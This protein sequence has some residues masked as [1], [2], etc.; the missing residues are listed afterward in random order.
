MEEVLVF[1]EIY[2]RAS[3]ICSE[4]LVEDH[5]ESVISLLASEPVAPYVIVDHHHGNEKDLLVDHC[6]VVHYD[7]ISTHPLWAYETLDHGHHAIETPEIVLFLVDHRLIVTYP[8]VL[9]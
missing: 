7:L 9:E 4:V 1:E 2:H 5:H 6:R 3:A 8:V